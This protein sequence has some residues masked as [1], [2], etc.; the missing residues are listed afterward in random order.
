[1]VLSRCFRLLWIWCNIAFARGWWI[2]VGAADGGILGGLGC[3]YLGFEVVLWVWFRGFSFGGIM[4]V[5]GVFEYG[6]CGGC[7]GVFWVFAL[8]I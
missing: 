4:L 2:L 3:C 1:M 8:V 7:M 6:G 5:G